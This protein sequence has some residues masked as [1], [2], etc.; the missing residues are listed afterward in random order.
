MKKT[1]WAIGIAGVCLALIVAGALGM[2]EATRHFFYSPAPPMPPVVAGSVNQ[3]LDE[4]EQQM[5]DKA[6]LMFESLQPGLTEQDITELEEKGGFKLPEEIKAIYR[7]HN[8]C[9]DWKAPDKPG[10]MA[11]SVGPIPGHRFV[12]LDEAIRQRDE[13]ARQERNA[14]WLQR[15]VG[16]LVAGHRRSWISLFDDMAGD[17]YF[18]DPQRM[19]DDGAVFYCFAETGT[20]AFFPSVKNLLAWVVKCYKTGAFAWHDGPPVPDLKDDFERSWE[21]RREFASS[22]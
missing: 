2:R 1:R 16:D 12:P 20:Y 22:P 8:G 5:K 19:Q 15:G 6:P 9:R 14:T 17:G 10:P 21:L 18:F 7:W 11:I 4:L 3:I 13:V